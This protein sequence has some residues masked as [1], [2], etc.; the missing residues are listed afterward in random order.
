VVDHGH[1][2]RQFGTR[3]RA[4]L[5]GGPVCARELPALVLVYVACGRRERESRPF[6][7]HASVHV[8]E[9]LVRLGGIAERRAL[10]MLCSR[11]ALDAAVA[12]G[13]VVRLGRSR[14]ALPAA[15]DARVAARRAGGVVSHLSA[16]LAHGWKVKVPPAMPHVTVRRTRGRLVSRGVILHWAAVTDADLVAGITDPV[17]T[18]VDCA[19]VLPFD[20]ALAVADSSLRSGKVCRAELFDAARRSP[21]TGRAAALRVVEAASRKAANPFES[22]LRAIALGVPGLAVVP[23][24]PVSAIGHADLTDSSLR[25]AIEA[26]SFEFH[27]LPEAFRYDVRRYTAMTRE[28]WLVARFVWEDV[29][30]RPEYVEAVLADL[31]ELRAREQAVRPSSA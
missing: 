3:A 10:L 18:V 31:V 21:R 7:E 9:A 13:A 23:Q 12:G 8:Q 29:M 4:G 6:G 27:T 24:G 15:D 25:I 20:E 26:E 14:Y 17:Q 11:R 28:G 1:E 5:R 16:A 19:R 2:R 30:R 22:T